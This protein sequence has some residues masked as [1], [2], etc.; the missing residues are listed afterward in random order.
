MAFNIFFWSGIREDELLALTIEDFIVNEDEYL[1]N[2]DKNHVV[3]QGVEYI[4][5]PK[6]DASNRCIN[7]P[8]FLY[9]EAMDYYNSLYEPNPKDRLFY[10]TKSYLLAEIKRVAKQADL[11][12]IRVHDLRHSH[13]SLLIEMGFNILMISQRLGHEK[14]QTTWDTYAHLYPDKHKMLAAQLDLVK[15]HGIT[16]NVSLED[17]LVS[18]MGQIKKQM[19][20]QPALTV[21]IDNEQ[22]IRWDIQVKQRV[23]V[24]REEFE[25]AAEINLDMESELAILEMINTGYLEIANAVYCLGSRGLPFQYL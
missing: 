15:V 24:T 13:A 5:T 20:S 4:L 1:L 9:K 23:L 22:I 7:I 16:A 10:F 6:T 21:N 25:T 14:V 12:P 17:Q 11:T 18:F 3:V 19:L 2:I 8:Q